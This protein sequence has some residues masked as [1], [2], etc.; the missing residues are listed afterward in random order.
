MTPTRFLAALEQ[1]RWSASGVAVWCGYSRQTGTDWLK[2]RFAI[3]PQVASWLEARLA[4]RLDDPPAR[5]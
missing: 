5:H 1:L 4:G 2:G 3:P